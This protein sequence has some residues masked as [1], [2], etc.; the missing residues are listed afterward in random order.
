MET[1]DIITV[2]IS[3]L[4]F[5]VATLSYL[6]TLR[7]RKVDNQRTL[8]TALTDVIAELVQV[9]WDRVDLDRND[10]SS[11]DDRVV[12]MRRILNNKRSYLARHGDFLA[13]QMPDLITDADFNSLARA[14]ADI[15]DYDKARTYWERCV[16]LSST[17]LI[18]A[19]NLRG[20]A[21]FFF[22]LGDFDAGRKVYRESLEVPL[23]DN[24]ETRRIKADTYAMWMKAERDFGFPEECRRLQDSA[25]SMARRIGTTK[26]KDDM[27]RYVE[28]LFNPANVA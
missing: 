13:Q 28:S 27:I 7:Q 3:S 5:L 6:N 2:S 10:D 11:N 12:D 15:G 22:R 25:I 23:P 21:R 9:D 8:R 26:T 4:A 14:F 17:P 20:F 16:I 19:M 1:K 24:D 18:R